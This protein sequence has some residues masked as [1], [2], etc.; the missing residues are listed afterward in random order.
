[1]PGHARRRGAPHLRKDKG[2]YGAAILEVYG[3][4]QT[5][6]LNY[7]RTLDAANDGGRWGFGQSGEPFPLARENF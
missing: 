2:L 1:M 4:H 3:P 7:L 5:D 6:W